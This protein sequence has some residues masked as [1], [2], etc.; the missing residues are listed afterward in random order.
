MHTRTPTHSRRSDLLEKV[1][2][3][4]ARAYAHSTRRPIS[5][6][7]PLP[8]P[9]DGPTITAPSVSRSKRCWSQHA[10][11]PHRHLDELACHDQRTPRQMHESECCV[12]VW[13]WAS[14][15]G[16]AGEREGGRAEMRGRRQ[17]TASHAAALFSEPSCT[18]MTRPAPL[19]CSPCSN[20]L[21]RST[22]SQLC[23]MGSTTVSY[24]TVS[25]GAGL[26][27]WESVV[28][29]SL[30]VLLFREAAFASLSLPRAACRPVQAGANFCSPQIRRAICRL[31]RPLSGL[32]GVQSAPP[33]PRRS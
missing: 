19:T 17:H 8:P 31:D 1:E 15:R 7:L 22:L 23:R 27:S 4:R 5:P 6:L 12:W 25:Y 10:A 3:S 32:F 21:L 9:W 16:T 24:A 30:H 18:A 20:T 2:S 33:P 14:C 13:V 11:P 29:G 28:R 26:G